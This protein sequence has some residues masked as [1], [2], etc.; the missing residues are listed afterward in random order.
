MEPVTNQSLWNLLVIVAVMVA[1]TAAI[2]IAFI[3]LTWRLNRE[4]HSFFADIQDQIQ[5][6]LGT[7]QLWSNVVHQIV[8]SGPA[9]LEAGI[10]LTSSLQQLSQYVE[11]AGG[12]GRI[13]ETAKK[14]RTEGQ[15]TR[16]PSVNRKTTDTVAK[17]T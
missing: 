16:R 17:E 14:A 7:Q 13:M 1:A 11:R 3:I 8:S 6:Y 4:L 2:N 9:I 15:G 5:R 12:I 10:R